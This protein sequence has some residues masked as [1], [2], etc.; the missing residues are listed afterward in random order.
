MQET[1]KEAIGDKTMS[2]L[3][4]EVGWAPYEM[5]SYLED[6]YQSLRNKGRGIQSVLDETRKQKE[7][8]GLPYRVAVATFLK[9]LDEYYTD[10][11]KEHGGVDTTDLL[12]L[13][14]K[15]MEKYK[16]HIN[17]LLEGRFK[18]LF[19]DEFQDTDK[20]QKR[21]IDQLL[22]ALR[23]ILVVGDRKQAIYGWRGAD[24]SVLTGMAKDSGMGD[25]L[26]LSVSRRPTKALLDAQN[27][28]FQ[29]MS[30]RYTVM[31]ELL[32][33]NEERPDTRDTLKP[34]QY[35]FREKAKLN[36]RIVATIGHIN[37]LVGRGKIDIDPKEDIRYID[38]SDICILFRSNNMLMRYAEQLKVNRIPYKIDTGGK[39][40][41]KPEIVG[42]FYMLQAILRYPNDV[43]LDLVLQTP[44]LPIHP[45]DYSL[46]SYEK[47]IDP[48]C[49]WLSSDERVSVWYKGMMGIRK[50]SKIDL[51][52]QLIMNIHEF[53]RIREWYTVQENYQA[54]ANLEK[55]VLWSREQMHSEALT[56]QQFTDRL[57]LAIL[58]GEEMEEADIGEESKKNDAIILSTIH[59][60]KGLEFPI[61]FLPEFQRPLSSDQIMP[62]YF[63]KEG[64]GIDVTLPGELGRSHDYYMREDE[65][66]KQLLE[67]EARVLYVAVTRAK[68]T[69]CFISG[70]SLKTSSREFWSWKDEVL[71]AFSKMPNELKWGPK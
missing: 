66:K 49:D 26:V 14:A 60:A 8:N 57:Q 45:L 11:K 16:N 7:D 6:I 9:R 39:F 1:M 43:T 65:Y 59:S 58:A 69:V 54:V 2:I 25:P 17:P 20:I 24:D 67:E 29:D 35:V 22:P 36:E 61:V 46:R 23:G 12:M 30:S 40:F 33:N 3:F 55:L 56:L 34:F 4:R 63:D 64:K 5:K 19:V 70:G 27:H 21:M 50:R 71:P 13:T 18:Y 10:I 41:S 15:V 31:K 42:F 52:P 44:F 37:L 32:E 38:F 68:N 62:L 48:L 53:T 51:V 47:D 28:L